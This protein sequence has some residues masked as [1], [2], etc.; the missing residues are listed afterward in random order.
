M[1]SF[2]LLLIITILPL[3]ACSP[4]SYATGEALAGTLVGSSAGAGVGWLLGER[5][6][7]KTKNV[8]VNSAIGAGVGVA[9]G[10]LVHE[11]TAPLRR[12]EDAV[13]REARLIGETQKEID[14]LRQS[15]YDQSSWGNNELKPWDERYLG[16]DAI[17][18]YQG[19]SQYK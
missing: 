19:Y 8:L 7:N 11:Q 5:V 2:Q 1:K 17:T 4:G 16:E 15:I 10:A 18:P 3:G 9:A 13:R 6:G 12:R 14:D